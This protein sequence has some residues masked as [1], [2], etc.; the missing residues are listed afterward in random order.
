MEWVLNLTPL[1]AGLWCGVVVVSTVCLIL[2]FKVVGHVIKVITSKHES[3]KFGPFSM[4]ASPRDFVTPPNVLEDKSQTDMNDWS[5]H[6]YFL[7]LHSIKTNGV[8]ITCS[9]HVK[10][11]FINEYLKIYAGTIYDKLLPWVEKVAKDNGKDLPNITQIM[12]E[13][14]SSC[15]SALQDAKVNI[16]YRDRI[17]TTCIPRFLIDRFISQYGINQS[18]CFETLNMPIDSVFYPDWRTQLVS[19]LAQLHTILMNNFVGINCA[20]KSL[21]G[22]LDE[23]LEKYVA[24]Y[25]KHIIVTD[26]LLDD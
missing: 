16:K 20:V 4:T 3:I 11:Q 13:I 9:S 1:V 15:I 17:I 5:R 26:Y 25:Y 2:L 18:E 8:K 24:K 7:Q 14:E 12:N 22:E 10:A 6:Q 19:I 21:N 23:Y